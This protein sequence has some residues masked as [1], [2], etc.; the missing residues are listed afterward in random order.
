MTPK[1]DNAKKNEQRELTPVEAA[2]LSFE[3]ALESILTSDAVQN[4][5]ALIS[6]RYASGWDQAFGRRTGEN[7]QPTAPLNVAEVEKSARA[8]VIEKALGEMARTCHYFTS[9]AE[10]RERKNNNDLARAAGR[11]H[12]MPT[13]QNQEYYMGRVEWAYQGELQNAYWRAV[14]TFINGLYH[15]VTGE[16][17][18][19]QQKTA[20]AALTP[21]RTALTAS[22]C[23]GRP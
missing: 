7:G 13:Q 10:E 18:Q 4:A 3:Q 2:C 14:E 6:A 11:D 17:Y 20:P 9:T 22:E 19:P 12:N 21:V 23:C 5:E 8:F 16:R 1:K 15:Y